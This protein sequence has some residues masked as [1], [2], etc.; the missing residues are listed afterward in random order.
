MSRI[1]KLW[2]FIMVVAFLS[3]TFIISF[4]LGMK[5]FNNNTGLTT[6][7]DNLPNSDNVASSFSQGDIVSPK[8]KIVLKVEYKK[9]GDIVDIEAVPS[10]FIGKDKQTIE[11][12]GYT[13]E[14]I[15]TEEVVLKKVVDS[16]APN[17]Y[18]LGVKGQ[19]IA[20]Y[21]TDDKGNM[22]IED[23]EKDVTD[24]EVPTQGDYELLLKGSKDFQFDTKEA[25]IEK[26]G[27]YDS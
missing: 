20:I 3:A 5:K 8:A 21:K 4:D 24:I 22:Y 15:S 23:I 11:K 25:V 26:L 27:E 13:V 12:L 7:K 14:S 17:K 9:S 18:V 16:Y 19:Y 2:V 6:Q 1:R 10:E